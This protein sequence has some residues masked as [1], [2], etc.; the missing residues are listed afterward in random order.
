M[1]EGKLRKEPCKE[2]KFEIR[3]IALSTRDGTCCG[4]PI[5]VEQESVLNALRNSPKELLKQTI[6]LSGNKAEVRAA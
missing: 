2:G 4:K 1:F 3:N 5:F 6:H